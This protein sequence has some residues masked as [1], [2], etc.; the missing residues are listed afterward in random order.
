MGFSWPADRGLVTL[1]LDWLQ[2]HEARIVFDERFVD[3]G[4]EELVLV[5]IK[6]VA[7]RLVNLYRSGCL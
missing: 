1:N 6:H 3:C 5:G 4:V 7:V 2:V